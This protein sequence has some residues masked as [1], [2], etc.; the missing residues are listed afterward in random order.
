[1]KRHSILLALL[2]VFAG[3]LAAKEPLTHEKLY[4]MKRVGTPALSPDGRWVAFSVTDPAYDSKEQSSDLW[5]APA[6]ASGKPRRITFTKGSEGDV[7]WSA[8]SRR[9]AFSAKRDGDEQNQIYVLNIAEGGEA[10]RVTTASTGAR[11]PRFRPDGNGIL[12]LSNVFRTAEAEKEAKERKTNVRVYE[13]FP[14]RSWDRWIDPDKPIRIFAQPLEAGAAPRDLLSGT[15][16]AGTPGFSGSIGGAGGESIAAEW[17]PDGQW[18]VFTIT[19][20]RNTSAYARVPIELYR[21]SVNGGEPERIAFGEGSY[22]NP[23]FSP[24]GRTL[25]VSFNPDNARTYNL[26]RIV[27]YDWPSMRNRR[28]VTPAPFD[29]H[30]GGFAVT[31]DGRTIYFTAE[32]SGLEKIYSVPAAGGQP[33]LAV[34]P[35]RGVYTELRI[36]ESSPSLVMIG[37][38]GSSVDPK[39]IVRIDPARKTRRN[40]TSFAVEDAAKID[41]QPPRHFWFTSS[42]GRQIHNMI[43]LPPGFD[44]SKKYP[45]FTLIHGGAHNMWRDDITLRWNYHLLA[46]PGYVMLLTNYTGSTGFGEKFAQ[47]IQGDPLRGPALEINEA[48]DEA[49][50]RFPFI[51]GSRQIAGGASYGGHLTN[52]LLGT[53]TRYK[54]LISHAGMVNPETQWGTSDSVFGRELAFGGP[55]WEQN[56]VWREQNAMRLAANF[57]TPILVSVGEKDFRVPLSNTL[58]LWTAL[59]RMRVPS[60]L[61]VFPEEN[62]WILNAENSRFF[63]QQVWDWIAKWVNS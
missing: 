15:K 41:W 37:R 14:I 7:T 61:L 45:V 12:Y 25:Y 42:R 5:I 6:D 35:E 49:I 18:I 23:T 48:V 33:V 43:V 24:D 54:V 13:S 39:E 4:L 1:M 59:Q 50:K 44:A 21:V 28:V 22:G 26:T 52:W 53:T 38:W 20:G 51:D 47:E 2:F 36:A 40:V 31:A 32:E 46:R 17:A 29:R 3:A 16:L 56:A 11:S 10:Q 60:K 62:H 58:E 63:Y 34:E 19:T 55:V 9:I 8:D 57:K 27:A 30:V